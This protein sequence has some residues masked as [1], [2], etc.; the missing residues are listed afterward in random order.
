MADR[1]Q[2]FLK[3]IFTWGGEAQ[4]DQVVCSRLWEEPYT[5]RLV[6]GAWG[7]VGELQGTFPPRS[8]VLRKCGEGSFMGLLWVQ[9]STSWS[10]LEISKRHSKVNSPY[11]LSHNHLLSYLPTPT[12]DCGKR[13]HHPNVLHRDLHSFTYWKGNAIRK[14]KSLLMF[15]KR[16]TFSTHHFNGVW[17]KQY[18]NMWVETI[19]A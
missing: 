8:K 3:I 1:V 18:N 14:Q 19:N 13:T 2:L 7:L 16:Y 17:S 10:C 11:C 9:R 12:G 4:E 6:P 15:W 5:T